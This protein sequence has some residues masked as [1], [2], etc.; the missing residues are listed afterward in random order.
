MTLWSTAGICS[1]HCLA[2]WAWPAV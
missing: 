2:T 1:R